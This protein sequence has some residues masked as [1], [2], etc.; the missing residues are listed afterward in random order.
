M[1]N[2]TAILFKDTLNRPTTLSLA[3]CFQYIKFS[4]IVTM[5]PERT[6]TTT[7][8]YLCNSRT[9]RSTTANTKNLTLDNTVIHFRS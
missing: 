7:E 5:L 2:L 3:R 1:S 4:P 9:P 6:L 8:V